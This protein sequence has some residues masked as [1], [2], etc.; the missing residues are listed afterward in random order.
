MAK[1][2]C[3]FKTVNKEV[4]TTVK[5]EVLDLI[6]LSLSLKEALV[7]ARVLG[8]CSGSVFF[9]ETRAAYSALRQAIPNEDY[10]EHRMKFDIMKNNI[11]ESCAIKFEVRETNL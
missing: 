6:N 11:F 9:D 8:R 2:V 7:V 5:S 3:N 10:N 4:T 1:A